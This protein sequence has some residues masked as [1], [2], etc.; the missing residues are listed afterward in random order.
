MNNISKVSELQKREGLSLSGQGMDRK[1]AKK[2]PMGRKA[3]FAVVG[4]LLLVFA[5][6]LTDTLLEGRSLSVDSQR[7]AVSTV[8]KGTFEDYIPLRGRLMPRSTVYLD[9]IEGGR[10]E[11]VLVEDGA[12][13]KA[14]DPIAI[15][16]NTNL[17]LAVL[18]RQ[19]EVTEQL[20]FMRTLELQLEQN[21]LSHKRNL[22]EI[23]YQITRLTRSI[24]RQRGLALKDMVS[25]STIDELEDELKY[26]RD[27]RQVTLESQA[28]DARLQEQQLSQLRASGEQLRSSLEFAARNLDELNV[29]APITGR[30]SGFN[31][32]VGQSIERGGRLGQIDDPDGFK[33][34]VRI[35]E[36]YM[37]RVD[38]KQ[39]AIAEHN[40]RNLNLEI[41]K[42]YPQVKDGQF[43][44][45]MTFIEEPL[46]LR[47]GQTL[48]VRLT[49][50]DNTGALLIPN[51]T[52]YQE[53]GGNWIFV[54]S[55]DGTEAVKRPVRLGRRNVDFIEVLDG[56]EAGEKVVTSPY[57]S[58]T[59][60]DR[61]TLKED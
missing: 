59:G 9:A 40:N 38:L 10:V 46:G 57:T 39:V 8:T 36:Y 28:T 20:N 24:D 60:M 19:A 22:V 43:E 35:D 3:G 1:V 58:Y 29:R 44:V 18:G 55:P 21:R 47:R 52:F 51:G 14:G 49:L 53:T 2:T 15:L 56:L 17:Q 27:R 7:I 31:I 16:S 30:L 26:Y 13:V 5:W 37:G 11:Q 54:V 23:D 34:N 25:Q 41:S 12:L 32:E 42:I 6:W 33:L 45:D 48:Q 50:G 61:L 4:I